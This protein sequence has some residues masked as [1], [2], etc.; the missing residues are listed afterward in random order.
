MRK[1][2]KTE[3]IPFT[4]AQLRNFREYFN[5]LDEDRSGSIGV[6]ELEGPLIALGLVDN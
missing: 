5:E 4:D 1:H 3:Y 6:P 2:G